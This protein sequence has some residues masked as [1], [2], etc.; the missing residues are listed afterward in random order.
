MSDNLISA[1]EIKKMIPHRYPFLLVDKV[2][3]IVLGKSC[4]GIKNFT[5]NE[6]FFQGHFPDKPIVPGVL[7]LEAMAQVSAVLMVKTLNLDQN[8]T[9]VLFASI[10]MAKFKK[11]VVPGDV[12]K[13]QI[14]V[15]KTKMG[16]T[17][18]EGKGFV[19]NNL[20]VESVFT[21]MIYD[22][23]KER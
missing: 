4:V 2:T 15:L 13:M 18:I 23:N 17:T 11:S 21:A 16:F 12:F 9:G 6:E 14:N 5:I 7:L 19:E 20:V 22:K 8:N 3:D 1:A 10:D